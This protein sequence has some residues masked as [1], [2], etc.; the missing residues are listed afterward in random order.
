MGFLSALRGFLG[1]KSRLDASEESLERFRD[2]WGLDADP[3]EASETPGESTPGPDAAAA[4]EFDKT[5]WRRK[6]HHIFEKYPASSGEWPLLMREARALKLD[7]AMVASGTKGEFI[8][9]I[10]ALIADRRLSE[11]DQVRVEE[12]RKL[13]GMSEEQAA[14]V[15]RSVVVDA[16]RFFGGDVV[17]ED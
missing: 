11:E 16:E 2:A 3:E 4:S 10:R 14:A 8:M 13:I 12:V 1:D 7:D 17:I 5:Q 15:V 9:M 6:L